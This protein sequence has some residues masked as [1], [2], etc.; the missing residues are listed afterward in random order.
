MKVKTIKRILTGILNKFAESIT[1]ETVK[2][3]VL[4]D[5]I[6]TGGSIASLLIKE[7]VNDYDLYFR[8]K[9]T[10]KAVSEYYCKQIRDAGRANIIILDKDHELIKKLLSVDFDLPWIRTEI[11]GADT[12]EDWSKIDAVRTVLDDLK[13]TYPMSFKSLYC[14][15]RT[16]QD[17]TE[18]RVYLKLM[19]GRFEDPAED[20]EEAL[21]EQKA[22]DPGNGKYEVRFISANAIT[23]SDR[24]Q[25]VTR[26]YGDPD[27]IHE[28]FDFVHATSYWTS[29][30]KKVVTNTEAL[31]SLLG[32]YLI[33]KGS[34][35][36][37]ASVLRARKFIK[38]GWN[39][40]AG[41]YLKMI[42]QINRLDLY[43]VYTLEEQLTGVDLMYFWQILSDL[44]GKL[45]KDKEFKPGTDYFINIIE[46]VFED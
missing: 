22:P 30:E 21:N 42:F 34:K 6:I 18:D 12:E 13:G 2:E 41:Q 25:I 37:V 4:R 11:E 45:I 20:P 38:R 19:S 9:A 23:L 29:W 35:Y 14:L 7:P 36:P 16:F 43:D 3:M 33:Y 5:T 27:K 28:N 17:D 46:K 32:R 40:D 1:D 39:I 26:F 31:E 44:S 8:S 10:V 15:K 24:I